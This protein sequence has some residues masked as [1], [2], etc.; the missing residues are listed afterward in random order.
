MRS[1][2]WLAAGLCLG[3]SAAADAQ[4]QMRF[5]GMDVNNDGVI[6]RSEWRGSDRAF[7]NQDWNGDGVLS[8]DEVRPGARRPGDVAGTAGRQDRFTAID[9]NGDGRVSRSEWRGSAAVFNALDANGD[10]VLTREEAVGTSTGGEDAFARIDA[11]NNGAI[12][13]GEW[14]WNPAAFDRLD[15]NRD[16]RVSRQEF[17]G[18]AAQQ[19]VPQQP[20][21]MQTVAYRSG[22]ERGLRE[23]TQ[24]GRED[25]PHGWDLE[26]QRELETADSGYEPRMGSRTEYQAG[27]RIGFRRG[28]REGFG[29]R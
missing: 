6:T 18:T 15:L 29:S 21:P 4:G 23:G 9:V 13:R 28:Y 27:Y 7:R 8:G 1:S 11:N 17:E 19:A 10:G 22:F 5:R 24:A 12:D 14:R 3:L 26:G 20:V 16:G 25:K 2:V